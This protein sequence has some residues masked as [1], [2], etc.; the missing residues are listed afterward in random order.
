M[1][2]IVKIVEHSNARFQ[3]EIEKAKSSKNTDQSRI[4]RRRNEQYF[5]RLA[6]AVLGVS[7][8]ISLSDKELSLAVAFPEALFTKMLLLGWGETRKQAKERSTPP[9]LLQLYYN[10][11]NDKYKLIDFN[12]LRE[13]INSN[14]FE[15]LLLC[16][17]LS[18]TSD[19]ILLLADIGRTLRMSYS[20]G[21]TN[22]KILLAD[23]TWVKYNRSINQFFTPKEFI[24]QLCV[25]LDKRQ[26]I[27]SVY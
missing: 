27:F 21:I 22:I 14:S 10:S 15:S 19:T 23:V 9:E 6:R 13:R 16:H 7:Q 17:G 20:I 26:R 24:N 2:E 11:F 3:E 25:C 1:L 5:T 18:P 8:N 4:E 12:K